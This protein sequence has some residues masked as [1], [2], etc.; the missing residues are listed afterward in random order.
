MRVAQENMI[1]AGQCVPR[2]PGDTGPGVDQDVV[3][4]QERG[5]MAIVADATRA[6]QYLDFHGEASSAYFVV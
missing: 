4:D 1:D 6:T 2:H 5:G 3:V